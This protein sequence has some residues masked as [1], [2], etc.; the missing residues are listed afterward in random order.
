MNGIRANKVDNCLGELHAIRNSIWY[1]PAP[2]LDTDT[3]RAA[4]AD[5]RARA[6]RLIDQIADAFG[7][8]PEALD[9][10]EA[11]M[12]PVAARLAE[13]TALKVERDALFAACVE[14]E[15][16]ISRFRVCRNWDD[17]MHLERKMIA[18]DHPIG[19][20]HGTLFA[21]ITQR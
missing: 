13:C 11:A 15:R 12:A 1:G 21:A 9:A 7:L 5:L 17:V 16:F 8:R 3:G 4:A 19:T 6:A 2:D 14:V 18:E 10:W 20:L